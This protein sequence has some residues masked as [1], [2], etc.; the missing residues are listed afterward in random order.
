MFI[1]TRNDVSISCAF[2]GVLLFPTSW[3]ARNRP[4][5]CPL[6]SFTDE[7]R[8][9]RRYNIIGRF[10]LRPVSVLSVHRPDETWSSMYFGDETHKMSKVIQ[11]FDRHYRCHLQGHLMLVGSFF[12]GRYGTG[13]GWRVRRKDLICEEDELCDAQLLPSAL[14]GKRGYKRVIVMWWE[15]LLVWIEE[16][17]WKSRGCGRGD[18]FVI[19][20]GPR[21]WQ[22]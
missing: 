8:I 6:M 5:F 2:V 7:I 17:F 18:W 12:F 1:F 20:I 19:T 11:R 14:F 21:K 9:I 13:S 16:G 15:V 22:I 10:I 3:Q 4:L